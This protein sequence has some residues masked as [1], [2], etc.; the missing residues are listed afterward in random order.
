MLTEKD[1][2]YAVDWWTLGVTMYEMLIGQPPFEA[3]NEEELFDRIVNNNVL[4]PKW[5]SSLARS[6][7]MQLLTK[8]PS[9]RYDVYLFPICMHGPGVK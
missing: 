6:L 1:Y 7:L 5:V 8:D 9:R 3:D 4:Y 2:G